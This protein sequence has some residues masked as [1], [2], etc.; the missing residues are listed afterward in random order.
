MFSYT[1]IQYLTGAFA[2]ALSFSNCAL[3]N[4]E[5]HN[6]R[7]ETLRTAIFA[8]PY[9]ELPTYNVSRKLFGKS[10]DSEDNKLREA[11]NRT[12]TDERDLIEFPEGQKLLQA[13]GICF[14]GE[15]KISPDSPFSG[16]FAADT[17]SPVIARTSVFFNGT[18]Q[19]NKRAVGIAIKL[20]PDDLE[21]RASINAFVMHSMGGVITKHTLDL[22]LDNE[23]PLGNLPRWKDLSTALR[24]RRDFERADKAN[25]DEK[26][27]INFRPITHL[28]R[29]KSKV[30]D[31]SNDAGKLKWMR[32]TPFST[33]RIDAD[34]FRHELEVTRYSDNQLVYQIDVAVDHGGKKKTATWQTIGELRFTESVVST[35]CDQQLHFQHP[36]LFTD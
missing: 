5:N 27:Q 17:R 32:L 31:S 16:L 24:I 34:D 4:G 1:Q 11:A 12:F 14:S 21:D 30:D 35:A 3:A 23:P 18:R 29:Y 7:Y 19:K 8:T 10:G 33:Q 25:S 13:N 36:T 28:A 6:N 15:W 9:N 2:V 20:L 26:A 22:S